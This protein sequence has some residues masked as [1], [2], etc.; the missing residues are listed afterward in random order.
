MDPENETA[1]LDRAHKWSDSCGSTYKITYKNTGETLELRG[2]TD[3][4]PVAQL[5]FDG[6]VIGARVL[7]EK[8]TVAFSEHAQRVKANATPS[9]AVDPDLVAKLEMASASLPG[10][11]KKALKPILLQFVG[12]I[13]E[14][15]ALRAYALTVAAA[16]DGEVARVHVSGLKSVS[17]DDLR[18]AVR[19][20]ANK[21]VSIVNMRTKTITFAVA[22]A[23]EKRGTK[24]GR[25]G[26]K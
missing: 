8:Q 24:R 10:E 9:V 17:S 13:S 21:A 4:L 26:D 20:G 11:V 12:A 6:G 2:V 15:G 25:E 5:L 1:V 19:A 3:T 23:S 14:A 7:F 16:Y 22:V 18:A